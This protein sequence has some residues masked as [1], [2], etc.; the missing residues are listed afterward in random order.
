MHNDI[1][2]DR[3]GDTY[4]LPS[5]FHLLLELFQLHFHDLGIG[6]VPCHLSLKV[7]T[8]Q[9]F[10]RYIKYFNGMLIFKFLTKDED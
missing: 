3:P 1:W 9:L 8:S 7:E 10:Y 4:R 5:V 6:H 2:Y